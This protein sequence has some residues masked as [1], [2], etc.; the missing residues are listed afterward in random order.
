MPT[1]VADRNLS[2]PVSEIVEGSAEQVHLLDIID[3]LPT[4]MGVRHA[5]DEEQVRTAYVFIREHFGHLN[6]IEIV[7]AFS[8]TAA[9]KLTIVE[10]GKERVVQAE[11]FQSFSLPYVGRILRAYSLKRS[12]DYVRWKAEHSAAQKILTEAKE[13]KPTPDEVLDYINDFTARNGEVPAFTDWDAAFKELQ[14]L[15]EIDMTNDEKKAYREAVVKSILDDARMNGR[16]RQVKG[17][18]S[19]S[20]IQGECRKR[21]V[22]TWAMRKYAGATYPLP[23]H[24]PKV[25]LKPS[26][27]KRRK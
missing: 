27:K 15:G 17:S 21:M 25:Q 6:P 20:A 19:E 8:L 13:P 4:Y 11:T 10:D 9:G 22:I 23:V 26:P 18:L 16:M 24:L 2:K 7:R 12:Q 3:T 5:L 1:I 14:R